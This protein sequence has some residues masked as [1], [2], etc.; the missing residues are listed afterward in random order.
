M[1][2]A[3]PLTSSDGDYVVLYGSPENI[4]GAD[5]KTGQI[6]NTRLGNF[7]HDDMIGKPFGCKVCFTPWGVC[8]YRCLAD[9]CAH[10]Q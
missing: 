6:T 2:L 4:K 3:Q 10:W 5:L 8:V 9:I 7:H 1:A